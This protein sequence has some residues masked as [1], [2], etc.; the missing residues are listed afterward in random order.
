[1]CG[2]PGAPHHPR[3]C[4]SERA[5]K[6]QHLHASVT[7]EG[8]IGDDLILD[9]IGSAGSDRLSSHVS[10]ALLAGETRRELTMAPTISNIVPSTMACLYVMDLDETLVAQALA[11]SS[12]TGQHS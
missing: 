2:V 7:P 11:T 1:M 5:G 10:S 4:G 12:V 6:R 8:I 9:G 3:R